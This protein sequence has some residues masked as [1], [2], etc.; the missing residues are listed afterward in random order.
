M[1]E[2]DLMTQEELIA[3]IEDRDYRLKKLRKEMAQRKKAY[4]QV[5]H[6]NAEFARRA[7]TAEDKAQ[8]YRRKYTM[9]AGLAVGKTRGYSYPNHEPRI[10]D[11]IEHNNSYMRVTLDFDPGEDR[12]FLIPASQ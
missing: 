4:S 5:E 6:A 12:T 9:K 7:R 1:I 10:F 8:E 11:V 3:E 2:L